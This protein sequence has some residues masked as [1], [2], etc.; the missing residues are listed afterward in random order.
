M[1]ACR[2]LQQVQGRVLTVM[3]SAL[4]VLAVAPSARPCTAFLQDGLLMGRNLDWDNDQGLLLVNKKGVSKR[5][6]LMNPQEKAAAWTSKYGSLT[7]N[8]YGRE[9]PTG[10]MNEAGLVV[11]TL[12]LDSTRHPQPDERPALIS[13]PQYQLDN[14]RTVA[15]VLATD[16]QIRISPTMPM[17]LH[18]FVCDREGNVAVIEFLDGKLV[19]HTD[20]TLA[21][22]LITNNTCEESL[23]FLG[24]HEGFGG[25]QQIKQG[26]WE[27]LDRYAIAAARLKAYRP[28]DSEEAALRYAFDT[29]AAVRQGNGTKW[30]VVY[31]LK[32]LEIHYK[33]DRTDR[34]RTVALAGLDFSTK[35]PVRMIS[36]NTSHFGVLNPYFSD[37]DAD[38]NRWMIYYSAKHTPMLKDLPDILIEA[39]ASY[40]EATPSQ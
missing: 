24:Q 10:G 9:M 31:D 38:V 14:C 5:A 29:L 11:E 28:P 16:K 39:F 13:W 6:M 1:K 19:C 4:A 8:Q 7:F 26:S 33:T 18:F 3:V 32:K 27:S 21:H 12:W 20:D 22:K 2:V 15:E 30:T 34:V 40:S 25:S 36:I 35:T 23:A 17:P 37:Y